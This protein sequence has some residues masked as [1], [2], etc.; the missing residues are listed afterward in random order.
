MGSPSPPFFFSHNVKIRAQHVLFFFVFFSAQLAMQWRRGLVR[1]QFR[2][3]T[4][5]AAAAAAAA[6]KTTE[7]N[8][9]EGIQIGG[10]QA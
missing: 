2:G 5:T 9:S 8:K 4:F 6:C 10:I 7:G 3:E 1:A